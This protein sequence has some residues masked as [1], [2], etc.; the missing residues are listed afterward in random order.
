M[1]GFDVLEVLEDVLAVVAGVAR[2]PQALLEAGPLLQRRVGEGQGGG[3]VAPAVVCSA[4]GGGRF[5]AMGDGEG[6]PPAP[7]GV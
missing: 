4:W 5:P 1:P 7:Y 6:L 3:V 2:A